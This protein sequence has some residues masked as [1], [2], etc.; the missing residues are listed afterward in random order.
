[1]L[2]TKAVN[3]RDSCLI[4]LTVT[5]SERVCSERT[6]KYL[7]NIVTKGDADLILRCH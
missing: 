1:M 7:S 2:K 6:Q 5:T 4:V 3:P